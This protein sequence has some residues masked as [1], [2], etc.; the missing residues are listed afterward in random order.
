MTDQ[1]TTTDHHPDF[2]EETVLD[3]LCEGY[4]QQGFSDLTITK[5]RYL[6][7]KGSPFVT[8]H[9]QSQDT[10]LIAC[11]PKSKIGIIHNSD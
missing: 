3:K 6:V 1:P 2:L 10:L 11:T 4:Q 7:Q 9:H 8:I 5:Y